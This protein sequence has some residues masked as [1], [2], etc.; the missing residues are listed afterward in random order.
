MML[1][2]LDPFRVPLLEGRGEQVQPWVH[3]VLHLIVGEGVSVYGLDVAALAA[4]E[5]H[6]DHLLN[7]AVVEV[8]ALAPEI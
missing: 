2:R 5:L 6:A 8:E 4:R 7:D 1:V 3:P